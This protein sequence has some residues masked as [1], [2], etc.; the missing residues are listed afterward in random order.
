MNLNLMK[1][2]NSLGKIGICINSLTTGIVYNTRATG[3]KVTKRISPNCKLVK[4][5]K[6]QSLCCSVVYVQD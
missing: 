2:A 5:F 1:G 3:R 4:I 6:S